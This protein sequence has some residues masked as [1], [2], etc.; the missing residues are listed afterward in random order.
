MMTIAE[1]SVAMDINPA[2]DVPS[3]DFP[4]ID[5]AI[6]AAI[7]PIK[8]AAETLSASFEFFRS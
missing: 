6:N 4:F 1:T 5:T 2:S 8:A 7:M 3:D